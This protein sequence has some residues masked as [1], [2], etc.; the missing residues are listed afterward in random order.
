MKLQEICQNLKNVFFMGV[1]EIFPFIYFYFLAKKK[2]SEIYDVTL[3]SLG[4]FSG[5]SDEKIKERL[6]HE[7]DRAKEI[8]DKT[9]KFTLVLSISLSIISIGASGAVKL[10]PENTINHYISFV[11]LLSSFYMLCG[12]LLSL[13]ALKTLPRFGYGSYFEMNID[14]GSLIKSIAGQEKVN[15]IRHMR[16]ELSYMSLRNGFLLILFALS[17]CLLVLGSGFFANQFR[18]E[19]IPYYY[20]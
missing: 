5:L 11:F 9:F 6:G 8:D 12:G 16:N 17:L 13:G 10:L 7:H 1:Q 3:S 2:T 14:R 20:L 15:M 4:F 18:F 19:P